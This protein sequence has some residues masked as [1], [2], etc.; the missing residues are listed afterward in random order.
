MKRIVI[1]G[2]GIGGLATAW[3]AQQADPTCAIT[4]CE[5]G[6]RW[7]GLIASEDL[8]GNRIETGPD[9]LLSNKA[10]GVRL[11]ESLGLRDEIVNTAP[12]ARQAYIA[13]GSDL[14]PIPQ[15]L[16]MVAPARIWPFLTSPIV[17]WP[18]KLRMAAELI[19]PRRKETGDE[20]LGAFVRRRMGR[21][22][23]ERIVQPLAGAIHS[24]DPDELSVEAVFPRFHELELNHGS[25]IRG[26]RQGRAV[27]AASGPRYGL[28]ISLRDGLGRLVDVLVDALKPGLDMRLSCPIQEIVRHGSGWLIRGDADSMPADAVVLAVPAP[29][30]ARLL[31]RVD[32]SLSALLADIPYH[33][34]A[35][36]NII[37]DRPSLVRMPAGAGLVVPR[38]EGRT[39]F[40][41]SFAS[42]KFLGRHRPDEV[43]LRAAVG[44]G[45]GAS[46]F[47]KSDSEI[48]AGVQRD[49]R[50]LV[51][52]EG[53]PR[54]VRLQRW[55]SSLPHYRVGHRGHI[56]RIRSAESAHASLALVGNAYDGTGIPDVL[57]G[58]LRA[59]SRLFGRE[60]DTLP[61]G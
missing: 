45:M 21:E 53:S 54:A 59:V 8:E 41:C 1:I 4:I 15:G 36:V 55:P 43:I 61:G 38:T 24:V 56:G 6:P 28:F 10:A 16:D 60:S 23:L 42:Q 48:L 19:I 11:I 25:I 47:R 14:V 35:T 52:M 49:L 9:A 7:G 20:S 13:R 22:V 32:P 51:G 58:S 26:L 5:S 57:A 37:C 27:A 2:G 34:V 40:A 18:A 29:V 17:S 44:G 50:E 39:I 3:H 12:E 46:I 30:S 31:H 33:G